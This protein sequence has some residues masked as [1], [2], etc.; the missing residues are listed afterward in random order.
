MR[1]DNEMGYYF[2][3][4]DTCLV[5]SKNDYNNKF[6]GKVKKY[7]KTGDIIT[8]GDSKYKLAD[9]TLLNLESI[10]EDAAYAT[11]L[12]TDNFDYFLK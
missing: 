5:L 8:I 2:F 6:Y 12:K 4:N 10:K 7:I 3:D 9:K 11:F 1:S